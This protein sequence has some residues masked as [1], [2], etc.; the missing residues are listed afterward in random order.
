MENLIKKEVE[1]MVLHLLTE[2]EAYSNLDS[3]TKDEILY[4]I[5]D[6][7]SQYTFSSTIQRKIN[8]FK[9]NLIDLTEH[10]EDEQI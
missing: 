1:A 5:Q 7:E 8:D 3:S 6:L 2:L 4:T 10:V 9:H